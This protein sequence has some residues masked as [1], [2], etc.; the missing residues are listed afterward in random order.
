MGFLQ[1][2]VLSCLTTMIVKDQQEADGQVA[3]EISK[4]L[5]L[6]GVIVAFRR[7]TVQW[8]FCHTILFPQIAT[9]HGRL[10]AVLSLVEILIKGQNL[11]YAVVRRKDTKLS[12]VKYVLFC[13]LT[14]FNYQNTRQFRGALSIISICNNDVPMYVRTMQYS[15]YTTGII[16]QR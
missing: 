1:C 13:V 15:M 8:K 12:G 5:P 10:Q 2:W 11:R 14:C 7:T 4:F 6:F 9:H 3:V 16:V